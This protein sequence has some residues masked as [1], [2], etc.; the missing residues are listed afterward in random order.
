MSY[1]QLV[2]CNSPMPICYSE[3][4]IWRQSFAI[5]IRN[6][7]FPVVNHNSSL[8]THHS[9]LVIHHLS[10]DNISFTTRHFN[11][12]SFAI[13]YAKLLIRNSSWPTRHSHSLFALHHSQ[14]IFYTGNLSLRLVFWQLVIH[15]LSFNNV[16]FAIRHCRLVICNSFLT[17]VIYNSSFKFASHL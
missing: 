11:N 6:L 1:S 9:Q 15:N 4:V 5:V 8:P 2:I 14:L 7:S 12:L 17:I 3:L 16:S 10:F 13:L